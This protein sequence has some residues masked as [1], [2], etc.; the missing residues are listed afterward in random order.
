[1][2]AA[3]W[4][5]LVLLLCVACGGGGGGGTGSTGLTGGGGSTGGTLMDADQRQASIT[6]ARQQYV[7]LMPRTNPANRDAYI[8]AILQD[9]NFTSAG[10]SEAGDN[11]FAIF[12]DGVPFAILDNRPPD[13]NP[14]VTNLAGPTRVANVPI[15]STAHAFFSLGNAFQNHTANVEAM[16][17]TAG[18]SVKTGDAQLD[19]LMKEIK[20]DGVFYWNTHSGFF[21]QGTVNEQAL[22]TT[23]TESSPAKEKADATLRN[24]LANKVVCIAGATTD[25]NPNPV[26]ENKNGTIDHEEQLVMKVVY[27]IT[28][29]FIET[30]M[31]FSPGSVVVQSSC[32]S[33]HASFVNAFHKAGAN[34]YFGWDSVARPGRQMAVLIDRLIGANLYDPKPTPPLR[35][36]DHTAVMTWMVANGLDFDGHSAHVKAYV[37][38]GSLDA[39]LKPSIR[40]MAVAEDTGRLTIRGSFGNPASEDRRVTM[41]GAE[42]SIVSWSP[43]EIV[44]TLPATGPNSSGEVKVGVRGAEDPAPL[45]FRESNPVMLTEWSGTLTIIDRTSG[46][47]LGNG[48]GVN[49]VTGTMVVKFRGDVHSYRDNPGQTPIEPT[50]AAFLSKPDSTLSY[51]SSGTITITGG[52]TTQTTTYS[53]SGTIPHAFNVAP[54][55]TFYAAGLIN[56]PAKQVKLKINFYK[57]EAFNNHT[58]LTTNSGSLSDDV[59]MPWTMDTGSE[60]FGSDI[61]M[62]LNDDL[63]IAPGEVST[64]GKFLADS[65]FIISWPKFTVKNAPLPNTPRSR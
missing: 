30:Y 37:K 55:D 42:L 10:W 52:D 65:G 6:R 18:Y 44:C 32:T 56:V 40:R 38:P 50:T 19:T 49:E 34:V 15:N 16:L 27:A 1:M 7:L 11:F 17:E 14:N 64:I 4:A 62:T 45:S 33:G 31:K 29:K 8:A 59:M 46:S 22:I 2:K 48:S 63:T 25:V 24:L 26:D 35:P 13:D 53:G 3:P 61:T 43:E 41:N 5:L 51:T 12:K 9:P 54:I 58:V 47:G 36:F 39:I 57:D 60:P 23:M 20:G 21:N 28:P